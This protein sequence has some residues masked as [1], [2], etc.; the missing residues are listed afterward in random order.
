MVFSVGDNISDTGNMRFVASKLES[1]KKSIEK[2]KRAKTELSY[3]DIWGAFGNMMD[4]IQFFNMGTAKSILKKSANDWLGTNHELSKSEDSIKRKHV[5]EL[6]RIFQ[7]LLDHQGLKVLGTVNVIVDE[8]CGEGTWIKYSERS[9]RWRKGEEERERIKLERLRKEEE[10]RYKDF[11]EK[12]E[13]WKSGE[14]NF[15]NTPFYIPGEKPNA[16]IRIK[17]NIIETSKQIKI[18]VAEARKLWRAVSAMHRGAEFRHGLVEDVTGHQWSLNRYE[19]DLLT[20]GCHRIAYNEM[21]RIAKQQGWV[22]TPIYK[23]RLWSEEVK[24]V[25]DKM[26]NMKTRTYE[27]VQHGDWGKCVLCGAQML[28]PCG[29]DKCPECGEN[30][31]LRWVDEERQEIDAKG[32]DCLDYVR[33]LRVDDYLSPTTLEEIAEEIKKKV[34][35]G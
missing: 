28:L 22:Y 8:V 29:A 15:L 30:G 33:E 7:I 10:A 9:E 6:K 20:V 4:Y 23:R 2:Y 34:N 27:G 13:E 17:G 11:D 26:T 31:T 24:V 18:G 25:N 21:E 32:L 19:N 1:I 14:I 35:R 12:L 5:H 16:W 3:I